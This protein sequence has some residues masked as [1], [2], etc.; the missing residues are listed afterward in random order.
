LGA[1]LFHAFAIASCSGVRAL[2]I[3]YTSSTAA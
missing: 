2:T 1:T 3:A